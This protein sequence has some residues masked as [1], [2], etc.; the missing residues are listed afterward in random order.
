MLSS[1]NDNNLPQSALT[2]WVN[3]TLA[4]KA[5]FSKIDGDASLT[6]YYRILNST[7]RILAVDCVDRSFLE[8]FVSRRDLLAQHSIIVPKVYAT[9]FKKGFALIED[10]G[11]NLLH[12]V[13]KTSPQRSLELYQKAWEVLSIINQIDVDKVSL[14]KVDEKF[15]IREFGFFPK[16]Y[17]DFHHK[18][19]LSTEE[20]NSYNS[21]CEILQKEFHRLAQVVC[22]RDYHSR[23]LFVL[24]EQIGVIDFAD[25]LIAP[26]SYDYVSL[27]HDLY[28][29]FAE[30]T[31][32]DYAIRQWEEAKKQNLPVAHDFG[33]YY[34]SFEFITVERFVKVLG[35]FLYLDQEVNRKGFL[36]YI[37]KCEDK[38]YSIALRYKELRPLALMIEDRVK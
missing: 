8:R 15:F 37:P 10:F 11:D 32:L 36:Q 28:V 19:P 9:N 26:M 23:N 25:M 29:D 18:K 2:T 16:W 22:H 5:E 3:D 34:R 6:K 31:L 13:L 20:M 4:L 7:Q 14:P 30:E 1:N 33:E 38:V 24:D 35:Q 12:E 17:A 27:L 21:V